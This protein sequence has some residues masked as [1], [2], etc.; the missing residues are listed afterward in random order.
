[1][2]KLID[3]KGVNS[4]EDVQNFSVKVAQEMAVLHSP[5]SDTSHRPLDALSNEEIDQLF[6]KSFEI[7]SSGSQTG[8]TTAKKLV[9]KQVIS[10]QEHWAEEWRIFLKSEECFL[11]GEK[12]YQSGLHRKSLNHFQRSF[13]LRIYLHDLPG[14]ESD[15]FNIALIVGRIASVCE[16]CGL[17]Q[18]ALKMHEFAL[19]DSSKV[20]DQKTRSN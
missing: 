11:E 7:S 12:L 4:I 15:E 14:G 1:M 16:F 10:E 2:E 17:Y 18:K 19:S 20:R 3:K 13:I 8:Y 5:E 9:E 6:T